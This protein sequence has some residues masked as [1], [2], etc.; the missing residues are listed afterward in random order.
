MKKVR[1]MLAAVVLL[2]STGGLVAAK[3]AKFGTVYCTTATINATTCDTPSA[4]TTVKANT[5]SGH[6]VCTAA[7]SS[8][9]TTQTGYATVLTATE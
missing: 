7:N 5:G 4:A 9:C 2:A 1:I 8:D 3:V 6:K